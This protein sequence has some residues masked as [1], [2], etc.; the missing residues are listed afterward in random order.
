VTQFNPHHIRPTETSR[1]ADR[2]KALEDLL[3]VTRAKGYRQIICNL[4]LRNHHAM[5]LMRIKN[6]RAS[7]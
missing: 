7:S 3:R 4:R 1:A 2:A 6:E 5:P